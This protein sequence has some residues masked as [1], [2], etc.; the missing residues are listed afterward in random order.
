M[1]YL[2]QDSGKLDLSIE[3]FR[4]ASRITPTDVDTHINLGLALKQKGNYNE[5]IECYQKAIE[6]DPNC[7][8][9]HFNLGN[10]Y[11]DVKDYTQAI[12]CFLHVL[13]LDEQHV[14]ALFNLAIAYHDRSITSTDPSS[15]S[16]Q[17]S[18]DLKLALDCYIRVSRLLPHLE[19]PKRA[20]TMI[21]N[22]INCTQTSSPSGVTTTST[23]L[24]AGTS[25][26]T[27]E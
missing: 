10:A 21:Q 23:P 6:Y 1:G 19:E 7:L 20:A 22:L 12:E 14:D 9:A 15:P 11:Q 27:D 18:S 8:M 3:C 26:I 25:T 24:S 13:R 5:A 16:N 17:R 2:Y 4:C